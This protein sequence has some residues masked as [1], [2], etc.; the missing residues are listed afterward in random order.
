MNHAILKKLFQN[1]FISFYFV[2]YCLISEIQREKLVP[3]MYENDNN[4]VYS[5][6]IVLFVNGHVRISLIALL[7]CHKNYLPFRYK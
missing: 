6:H 4:G 2:F 3:V 5:V 7:V 1:S